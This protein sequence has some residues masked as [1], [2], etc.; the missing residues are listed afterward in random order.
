MSMLGNERNA[1]SQFY[2]EYCGRIG[3]SSRSLLFPITAMIEKRIRMMKKLMWVLIVV[4]LG[5][6]SSCLNQNARYVMPPNGGASVMAKKPVWLSGIRVQDLEY[7]YGYP[8]P[9]ENDYARVVNAGFYLANINGQISQLIMSLDLTIKKV[10]SDRVYTKAILQNPSNP[11][12]PFIYEHY[13]DTN[14]KSTRVRHSPVFNVKMGDTYHLA[15]EFYGDEARTR[16]L[17]RIDQVIKSPVDNT[18]GCVTL[19]QGLKKML[20]GDARDP[21]GKPIPLDKI[22]IACMKS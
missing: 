17:S 20:Y 7:T 19:D 3:G 14:N 11:A 12:K 4:I 15:V 10:F 9:V 13:L 6:L 16:L 21:L 1:S 22:I 5:L 8:D 2:E 18:S